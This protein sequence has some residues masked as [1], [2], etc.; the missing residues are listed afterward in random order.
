MTLGAPP[1]GHALALERR[2]PLPSG[3]EER[4]TGYG[5]IGLTFGSG[6][7][8]AFRRS[9]A[10]SIGP[11]FTSVWHRDPG[12]R[13]THY[14]DIEPGRSF[15]RYF[16]AGIDRVEVEEISLTWPGPAELT[17]TMPRVPFQWALRLRAT[18]RTRAASWVG[19]LLPGRLWRDERVLA[20]VAAAAARA[21]GVGRFRLHGHTPGGYRFRLHPRVIWE[22]RASAAVLRGADLGTLAALPGPAR[23]G[24]FRI[25]SRGLFIVG[26]SRFEVIDVGPEVPDMRRGRPVPAR[27][28]RPRGLDGSAAGV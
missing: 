13:W 14:V 27:W 25:P 20:I 16:G 4:F 3:R 5:A 22:V 8:L 17:I 9:A 21:L 19:R 1:R 23:F 24:E 6:H 28:R 18:P 26:E 15:H 10:S 12:G 11:P 7:V 2:R